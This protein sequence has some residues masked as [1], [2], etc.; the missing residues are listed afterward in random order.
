MEVMPG[1]KATTE[2]IRE[3]ARL[4]SASFGHAVG[5][6]KM[7]VDNLA[8][9]DPQLRLHGLMGLRVADASVMP[10]IITGPTNAP[11]HMIAGRGTKP[12]LGQNRGCHDRQ[13]KQVVDDRHPSPRTRMLPSEDSRRF[14]DPRKQISGSWM[15]RHRLCCGLAEPPGVH[16]GDSSKTGAL[17]RRCGEF[18][19][20]LVRPRP[21]RFGGFAC[22]PCRMFTGH[23]RPCAGA[24][25]RS[26]FLTL[27][28]AS[29]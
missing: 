2:E 9:V 16:T 23:G 7:G 17:A 25:R 1:P 13:S 21:E 12:I 20:E 18:P 29:R 3:L 15:R 10:R 6:C 5:T 14:H 27:P 24:P 28:R 11:T 8:V 26:A 22:P 4:G 19:A